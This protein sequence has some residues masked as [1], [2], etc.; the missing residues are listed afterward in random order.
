[1]I[2]VG[3]NIIHV[4]GR[5]ALHRVLMLKS[6]FQKY[7]TYCTVMVDATLSDAGCSSDSVISAFKPNVLFPRGEPLRQLGALY[8]PK[9]VPKR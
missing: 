5:V 7:I 4:K 3:V 6:E 2:E 1:M 8:L 9:V